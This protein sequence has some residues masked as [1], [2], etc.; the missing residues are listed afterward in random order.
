MQ[1]NNLNSKV[2]NSIEQNNINN[3]SVKK[4]DSKDAQQ[5][6]SFLEELPVDQTQIMSHQ[7]SIDMS[8]MKN[9]TLFK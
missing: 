1:Q 6:K 2:S 7:P 8:Q 5:T 4:I 3:K 9:S